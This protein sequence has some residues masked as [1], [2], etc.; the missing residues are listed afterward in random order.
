V[1]QIVRI[2]A[3]IAAVIAGLAALASYP[4]RPR[5]SLD[6]PPPLLAGAQI[7]KTV[8]QAIER[9]C[10]DCHSEATHYRWYSYIAPFSWLID[11]DVRRGRERL[12]LSRWDEYPRVRRERALSE[13]AN[14]VR[15]GGMPLWQYTWIHRDAKLS[16]ADAEAIFQWT[17]AERLRLI[18]EGLDQ[19]R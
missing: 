9:S 5:P 2:L 6:S 3:L 16:D 11:S 10:R 1:F 7:D 17:Q 18:V 4:T 19:K 15:D 13:I 14:Q 12:N 8:R